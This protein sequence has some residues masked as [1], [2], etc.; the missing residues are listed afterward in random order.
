MKIYACLPAAAAV[1]V[2]VVKGVLGVDERNNIPLIL[3]F[4]D[5]G[6][7]VVKGFIDGCKERFLRF[8][9]LADDEE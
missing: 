5:F 6:L 2:G 1:V 4:D 9:V 3:Y 8:F 7:I